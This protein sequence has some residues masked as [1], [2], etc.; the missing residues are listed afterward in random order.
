MSYL[1]PDTVWAFTRL[2]L[3]IAWQ[4]SSTSSFINTWLVGY[5]ALLGPVIGVVMADYF[6]VR[7]RQL[8][9]DSLYRYG[10]G[11]AYWYKVGCT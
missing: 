6:L 5:S 7:D 1:W 3:P 2:D 8:D 11:G 4:V 10:E 9:I